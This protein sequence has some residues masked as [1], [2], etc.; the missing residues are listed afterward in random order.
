VHRMRQSTLKRFL[1]MEHFDEHLALH[2]LDCLSSNRRLENYEYAKRLWEELPPEQLRPV[3]LITGQ[4]LIAAGH[5]PG[6]AF[7]RA[8]RVVE[9]AQLE[10]TVSTREEALELA[11]RVMSEGCV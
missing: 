2:R 3:R 10:G 11:E 7:A 1:R 8:L 9:D 4:D 6:P 5:E